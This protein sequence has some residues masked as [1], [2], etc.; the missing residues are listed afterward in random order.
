MLPNESV[1]NQDI[2][3]KDRKAIIT[4]SKNQQVVTFRSSIPISENLTLK[5]Y[6]SNEEL[7]SEEWLIDVNPVWHIEFKGL[8]SIGNVVVNG[9]LLPKFN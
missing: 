4:L 1:L 3:T 2:E 5:A 9:K 6:K 8:E 7:I